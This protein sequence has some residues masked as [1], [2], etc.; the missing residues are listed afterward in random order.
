MANVTDDSVSVALVA[1]EMLLNPD[2]VFSCHW[3]VN[4]VPVAA[5]VKLA[6]VPSQT[7]VLIGSVVMA[8]GAS[9]VITAGFEATVGAQ[10]P[11]TSTRYW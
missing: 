10:V 7:A 8:G 4:P 11:V 3:Y 6:L 9:T 5:A 2:P 1:P